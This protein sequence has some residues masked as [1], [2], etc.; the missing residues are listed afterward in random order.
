MA[1]AIQTPI[2]IKVYLMVSS[3]FGQLT[4]FI[5]NLTSFRKVTI[6]LGMF[7]IFILW[8]L[9]SPCGLQ[10]HH[11]LWESDVKVPHFFSVGL[12]EFLPG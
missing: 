12:N 1:M 7:D 4:F 5:S 3:L 2:T 8:F 11:N 9:K 10:T 6:L